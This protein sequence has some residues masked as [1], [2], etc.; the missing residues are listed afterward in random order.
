MAEAAGVPSGVLTVLPGYGETAQLLAQH[1]LVRK[2]D[3]TAGTHTG[4]LLGTAVG[5]NLAAFTA[6][7][8]GK[9]PIVVFDD[10]DVPSAVN[11]AAFAA[12]VA[13][14]QTCV[15]GTRL[16]VHKDIWDTFIP[17]FVDKANSIRRRIGNRNPFALHSIHLQTPFQR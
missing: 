5:R 3:L 1:P 6:E 9:A 13:A 17:L 2:V 11:G 10:A 16:I 8:G 12:F 15:S 4:R 14:G 7:L